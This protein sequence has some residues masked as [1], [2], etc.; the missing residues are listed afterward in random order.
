M[1]TLNTQRKY[2][3]EVESGDWKQELNERLAAHRNRRGHGNAKTIAEQSLLPGIE[4][5]PTETARRIADKVAARYANAPSYSELLAGEA[6]AAARAAERAVDAAQE[7]AAAAQAFLQGLDLGQEE[8][9]A[10]ARTRSTDKHSA[11]ARKTRTHA[12]IPY[13]PLN[14]PVGPLTVRSLPEPPVAPSRISLNITEETES[15]Y[16]SHDPLADATVDAAEP[17]PANLIQFPRQIIATRR[18]QPGPEYTSSALTNAAYSSQSAVLDSEPELRIFEV[19]ESHATQTSDSTSDS[20]AP[21]YVEPIP[22]TDYPA[23]AYVEQAPRRNP[24]AEPVQAEA[25]AAQAAPTL[26]PAP[27]PQR[28]MAILMDLC[29]VGFA[30]LCFYAVAGLC[31]THLPGGKFG[32]GLASVL[33]VAIELL[34]HGL[35]LSFAEATPGMMYAQVGLCTF[36]DENLTRSQRQRRILVTVLAAMPLGLGLLWALFDEDRL[37]WQDRMSRSYQRSYAEY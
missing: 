35:F 32:I 8:P 23:T 33:F 16:A 28:S 21:T 27:L 24:F 22:A 12:E 3:P 13:L 29:I 30:F 26:F 37:G 6:R 7:A 1:R 20:Y 19:D 14:P 36:D 17:I 31:T 4:I 18:A 5:E 34:Y 2:S 15:F 10:P 9:I 25:V 11:D